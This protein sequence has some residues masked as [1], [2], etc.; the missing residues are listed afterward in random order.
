MSLCHYTLVNED[1]WGVVETTYWKRIYEGHEII[2]IN[3]IE[4]KWVQI[5]IL[6]TDEE[7]RELERETVITIR[8]IEPFSW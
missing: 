7:K 2:L 1:K 4:Y 3:T 5:D 8:D 6:M